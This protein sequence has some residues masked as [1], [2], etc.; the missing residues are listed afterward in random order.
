MKATE[1]AAMAVALCLSVA[2]PRYTLQFRSMRD[3]RGMVNLG[4]L[5]TGVLVVV[6]GIVLILALLPVLQTFIDDANLTGSAA[7]V[8]A[9]VPIVLVIVVIL[10]AL[11][12]LDYF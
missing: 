8:V 4:H 5:V 2:M 10:L 12:I 3:E 11:K 7:A 1:K 9:I 6:L